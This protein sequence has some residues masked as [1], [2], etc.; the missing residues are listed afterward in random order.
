MHVDRCTYIRTRI[1]AASM[2]MA[3][4]LYIYIYVRTIYIA[5][6]RARSS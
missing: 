6:Y 4:Q 3:M 2:R 1:L 5:S